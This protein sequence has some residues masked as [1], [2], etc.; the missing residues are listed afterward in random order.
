M[1]EWLK[2]RCSILGP[3]P[4]IILGVSQVDRLVRDRNLLGLVHDWSDY[5]NGSD[6]PL[7]QA[8]LLRG[9]RTGRPAGNEEFVE[10]LERKK[11][12]VLVQRKAGAQSSARLEKM[13]LCPRNL[14][15]TELF[16]IGGQY[17]RSLNRS[18]NS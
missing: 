7:T 13:V 1:R 2:K 6:E 12:R 16:G 9:L 14:S 8:T 3:V 18:L 17:W 15:S 4:V 5:L 11:G 10:M